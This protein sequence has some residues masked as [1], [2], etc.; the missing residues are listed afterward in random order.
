PVSA[1]LLGSIEDTVAIS[2][3]PP[4][5]PAAPLVPLTNRGIGTAGTIADRREFACPC[6]RGNFS[7]WNQMINNKLEAPESTHA[8]SIVTTTFLNRRRAPLRFFAR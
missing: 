5:R 7:P 4:S 8:A 1:T 3:S 6:A 2:A